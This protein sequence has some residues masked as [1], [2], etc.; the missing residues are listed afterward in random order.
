MLFTPRIYQLSQVPD[1]NASK[2]ASPFLSLLSSPHEQRRAAAHAKRML[3]I[4]QTGAVKVGELTRYTITYQPHADR[5]IPSPTHLHVR[6][7]NTSAIPLRAAYLNGPYTLHVAAY[8]STFDPNT[9]FDNPRRNGVPQFE[10]LLKAGATFSARLTIPDDLRVKTLADANALNASSDKPSVTWIL[11]V[12]SQILFSSSASVKFEVLVGRDEKS[13]DYTF[14]AVPGKKAEPGQ[15]KD[16]QENKRRR[17]S[18]GQHQRGVYSKAISLVIDDTESL[19]DRPELPIWESSPSENAARRSSDQPRRKSIERPRSKKKKKIHLVVVT[20]GL[21]S[22]LGADMLFM[23]ESID[24]TAK[25]AREKARARKAEAKKS[26]TGKAPKTTSGGGAATA[27]L[28]GGQED[29]P[30][31]DA[32]DDD[33]DD[34][35]IIV[36]GF[37]GNATKTEKGIQYLGKRLARH[38]L[39]QTFPDQ[40]VRFEKQK[41]LSRKVADSFHSKKHD[42][43]ETGVPSHEGSKI[44]KEE[45]S[46]DDLAYTFTS[47]SF[48][49]HSLGGLTQLY[50]IAYIQKHAPHFFEH[51]KPINFIAMASP[52]LGLSNENPMYVKFALDFGLVGRT[53]QDL[54]LTWRAPTLAKSGWTALAGGLGSGQKNQNQEDPGAKPLLRILPTGPA[55]VILRKFRNRTLYSN[56]VN[57]G[58]VPLR[59]S[60]LLFLDWRGLDKVEKA[61]R[62]NGLVGTMLG[63]GWAEV[64]GQNSTNSEGNLAHR[65]VFDGL[66]P[67]NGPDAEVPQPDLDAI[68]EDDD[69]VSLRSLR[70]GASRPTS[71]KGQRS[72]KNSNESLGPFQT[73][74]SYIRPSGK[75]TKKDLRMFSRSQT[76]RS[77]PSLNNLRVQG[78]DARDQA[79]SPNTQGSSSPPNQSKP[80]EV[81]AGRPLASR[82]DSVEDPNNH[83]APPKTT[84]FESAA[85][86]LSPP[87][88]PTS[89]IIDPSTR[90][91]TIFHDRV[92]HPEDIPPPPMPKP[93]RTASNISTISRSSSMSKDDSNSSNMRVEEKIARAYHRDLS[94]RKVLVRLEPD[95]HNNM[96]V[97]RMFANAYG[98]PVVKHLCDTHFGD[99]FTAVTR[100]EHEASNDR[101]KVDKAIGPGGELVAGQESSN[102]P[103]LPPDMMRQDSGEM[104]PLRNHTVDSLAAQNLREQSVELDDSYL[105]DTDSEPEDTRGA[106]QRLWS[107]SPKSPK[108]PPLTPQVASHLTA[109]PTPL[110]ESSKGT[111]ASV[112]LKKSVQDVLGSTG[113]SQAEAGTKPAE[114]EDAPTP[115]VS[116][117]EQVARSV[118]A[119][120]PA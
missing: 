43:Q 72:R 55:H 6:I 67:E 87:T 39:D 114:E 91:R 13:L 14:S 70:S 44:F 22:N 119:S 82:G 29:I 89:W 3:L 71:S 18:F 53:G 105:D 24:A 42:E 34:E 113:R 1:A 51:V 5:I 69:N 104:K 106:F 77:E 95:A 109:E 88:P 80:K 99:T 4:H 48:I 62:D 63:W 92:Y 46:N 73:L 79:N 102:T 76:L 30:D 65:D 19:W 47:I 9:K 110:S 81:A 32:D 85:D 8:P 101:A 86:L 90:A 12:T 54:G 31:N 27:P 97:R 21:H 83:R 94:W 107:P 59:T 56:V 17:N 84:I 117:T 58:I 23:K 78:T 50:A 16:N 38:I 93:R 10:P 103:S 28:S 26:K 75:T 116:I 60:C 25:H 74:W 108:S 52:L 68:N 118:E 35:Q 98:W 45:A 111:T 33:S 40:P 57:D 11:E 115:S 96:I 112:G 120:H 2:P 64:T 15:I 36:R 66:D 20:H 100:D 7:R 41:S 61:R 37:F 49:G